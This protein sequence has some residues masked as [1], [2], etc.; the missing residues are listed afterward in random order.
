MSRKERNEWKYKRKKMKKR[1]IRRG[2]KFIECNEEKPQRII[3]EETCLEALK[4]KKRLS[5]EEKAISKRKWRETLTQWEMK[6]RK[7]WNRWRRQATYR[8]HGALEGKI[9]KA[10]KAAER[11]CWKK[12]RRKMKRNVGNE[13]K[14]SAYRRKWGEEISADNPVREEEG[15]PYL[16]GKSEK[17]RKKSKWRNHAATAEKKRRHAYR[18]PI[19]IENICMKIT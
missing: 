19:Q 14:K 16:A 2:W 13:M 9:M 7:Q 15:K 18:M 10:A 6:W 3:G 5:Q 17:W 11:L 1:K 12:W 8:G 4:R